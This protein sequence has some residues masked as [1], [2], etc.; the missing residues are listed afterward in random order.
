MGLENLSANALSVVYAL[1]ALPIFC[2]GWFSQIRA[3]R[4]I[5]KLTDVDACVASDVALAAFLK[6][7]DLTDVEVVK[8]ENYMQNEYDAAKNKIL[9]SPDTLGRRDV[10]SVALALR[11]GAQAVAERREPEKPRRVRA[12]HAA[13]NIAFWGAF[14]ILAF[15]IMSATLATTFLGY[16][17][18]LLVYGLWSVRTK[19]LRD[20]DGV[21]L[22]FAKTNPAIPETTARLIEQVLKAERV[23]F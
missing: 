4:C 2:A 1:P 17:L 6:E 11:A 7:V 22:K 15:G 5:R 14:S 19:I 10:A 20:V 13:E 16:A 21:A 18:V 23:K 8:S 12:L 3:D 9:L